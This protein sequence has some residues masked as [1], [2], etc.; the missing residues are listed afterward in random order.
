MSSRSK[1][2]EWDIARLE[3]EREH[4]CN[5]IR[6][7]VIKEGI[8]KGKRRIVIY[9]PVKSGKRQMVEFIA[10]RNKMN[11]KHVHIF[12]TA[13]HRTADEDQ[14]DELKNYV[15][16]VLSGITCK[17]I[18]DYKA[19]IRKHAVIPDVTLTIHID[20]CDYGSAHNQLLSGI[21]REWHDAPNITFILY[22]ATP[23]EVLFSGEIDDEEMMEDLETEGVWFKYDPPEEF[24]GP[25]RFLRENIVF[26]ARPFFEVVHGRLTLTDQARQIIADLRAQIEVDIEK[27]QRDKTFKV[28]NVLMLRMC[29]ETEDNEKTKSKKSKKA[30]HQFVENLHMFPEFV[31]ADGNANCHFIIDKGD[32]KKAPAGM[33]RFCLAQT[34]QWSNPVFWNGITDSRP[35]IIINDQT[36]SRSTE[37]AAHDRIFAY[38]DYRPT[39][40]FS[41]CSQAFERVN[42][43][44]G[45][46][47]GL[48]QPIKIYC[49]KNTLRLSAGQI[50]YKEYLVVEWAMRKQPKTEMFQIKKNDHTKAIHPDYPNPM[51]EADAKKALIEL[52]CDKEIKIS[53]RVKGKIDEETKIHSGFVPCASAEEFECLRHQGRLNGKDG[54][55]P[56]ARYNPF[57]IYLP[58][59]EN[60][61][62]FMCSIRGERKVRTVEEVKYEH[63][64]ISEIYTTRRHICYNEDDVCGILI[65]SFDGYHDVNSFNTVKSM[66]ARK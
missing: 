41:V 17:K 30:I 3:R 28:R 65:Q 4:L 59:S 10:L 48:F 55:G 2:P 36:C 9:A 32:D 51:T 18:E 63:W 61:G 34:V 13:W 37:L 39:I 27:R 31:D 14:R 33:S 21:W 46:Y 7:N 1:T 12:L 24:C 35:V 66:Y 60:P 6:S 5:W 53:A 57:E 25:E 40:T 38:H 45:K 42:H 16:E 56:K 22:S 20:E 29:C 8:E 19:K 64:G 11:P 47:S 50:S 26:E 52:G 58:N 44:P 62:R 43:Y 54:H 49:H 23:Q 15:T